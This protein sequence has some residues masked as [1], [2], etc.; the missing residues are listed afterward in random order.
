MQDKNRN[1]TLAYNILGLPRKINHTASPYGIEFI[2][3][4]AGNKLQKYL[5]DNHAC[6]PNTTCKPAESYAID[7]I[8]NFVYESGELK[9]IYHPRE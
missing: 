4:A 5:I 2:Y 9:M 1:I 8:G 7:Y 6:P 3:D